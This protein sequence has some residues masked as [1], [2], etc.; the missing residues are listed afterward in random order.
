MS[1]NYRGLLM[2]Q[3]LSWLC[4]SIVAICEQQPA[5]CAVLSP[6][7]THQRMMRLSPRHRR[8]RGA[9]CD[10][11]PATGGPN[12]IRGWRLLPSPARCDATCD[13]TCDKMRRNMRLLKSTVPRCDCSVHKTRQVVKMA[14]YIVRLH[15]PDISPSDVTLSP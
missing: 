11:L 6:S 9:R 4:G 5:G 14:N 13:A 3:S 2:P 12:T 1:L 10:F 15:V 8:F 7:A